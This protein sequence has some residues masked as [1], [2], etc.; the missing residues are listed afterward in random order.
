[1]KI[2]GVILGVLTPQDGHTHL[3]WVCPDCRSRGYT[4]GDQSPV[5]ITCSATGRHFL[6]LGVYEQGLGTDELGFGGDATGSSHT[7]ARR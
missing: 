5:R 2:D 6:V 7:L 4:S 3:E 1:M